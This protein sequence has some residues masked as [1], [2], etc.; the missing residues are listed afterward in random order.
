MFK[1]LL[2]PLDRSPLAEQ[3]VGTAVA[4]AREAHAAIDLVLVHERPFGIEPRSSLDLTNWHDDD[5]YLA[6]IATEVQA[7]VDLPVTH[8]VPTG[9]PVEMICARAHAEGVDLI[10]MTSHGRTGLSRAFLGSVADGVVRQSA[11]PVLLLRVAEQKPVTR[12]IR[13][14]PLFRRIL[15]PLDGSAF[16]A[17]VLMSAADLARCG[18]GKLLLLRVVPPVP[19]V[20]ADVP[21]GS[22]AALLAEVDEIATRTLVEQAHDDLVGVVRSLARTGIADVETAVVLDPRVS[23]AIIDHAN[24]H[25]ADAIAMSTHGRG[26][27][28]LV[29]GSVAD[30]VMRNAKMS[31][32][33]RRPVGVETERHWLSA[34]GI[35]EQL[36][37]I[38]GAESGNVEEG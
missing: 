7:S 2:V 33:L 22:S 4:I 25:R 16:S 24:H 37:A 32:L 5:E 23:R 11:V 29:V 34:A 35:D 30:K 14:L 31:I 15:V 36:S 10:V 3:A 38:A 26:A 9:N 21:L 27:T 17:D 18:N 13:A 1:K 6:T 28:R 20:A 19:K 12:P 8:A